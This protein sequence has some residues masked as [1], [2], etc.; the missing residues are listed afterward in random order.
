MTLKDVAKIAG[1]SPS[2]VSRIINSS[3]E[4][5][6]GEDVKRRVWDAVRKTGYVPNNA[7]RQLKTGAESL[8]ETIA[9]HCLFARIRDTS[10]ESSFLK[11]SAGESYF[12]ELA[13]YV[14]Q[15][16]LRSGCRVGR[17]FSSSEAAS[18]DIHKVETGHHDGLVILGK[19]DTDLSHFITPFGKRIVYITLNQMSIARDHIM[20]D[21]MQVT[22]IA[23]QHLYDNNHRR[24]S[25]VGEYQQ[26]VRYRS[27][28]SFLKKNDLKFE[29]Q[30][31]INTPMTIEGGY[32][33]AGR[34]LG[35][36]E[37]P[38]AVFCANDATAIGLLKGLKE[39]GVSVPRD[40]S[41]I[42][43]DNI[44]AASE[45]K[46]PL[47]TVSIPLKDMGSFA[48]KT[49]LDRIKKGHSVH[50]NVFMPPE[51]VVRESV[52]KV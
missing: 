20:C 38:T 36:S 45:T 29:R 4:K 6:A 51:L 27:Y 34:F 43:I 26:E 17:R 18:S 47:T 5:C 41:V 10:E 13:S 28:L 50:L 16:I 44:L 21:G 31:I 8:S 19:S 48:V 35:V 22:E 1:V 33:A 39:K 42:S 52:R 40:L 23:M 7:A 37:R 30:L 15:E 12:L 14:E 32:E 25:Y 11:H 9:I 24:I 3:D 49:L 46:P 2:T